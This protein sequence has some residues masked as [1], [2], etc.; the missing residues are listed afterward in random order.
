[1]LLIDGISNFVV[2]DAIIL[3]VCVLAMLIKPMKLKY[4]VPRQHSGSVKK[5]FYSAGQYRLDLA[6]ACDCT[7]RNLIYFCS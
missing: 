4:A 1:M 3:D 7:W 2:D 5:D 6:D